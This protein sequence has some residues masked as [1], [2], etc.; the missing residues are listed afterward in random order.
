MSEEKHLCAV[1]VGEDFLRAKISEKGRDAT[2]TY[3]GSG[4]KTFSLSEMADAIE[5]ALKEHF[6]LTSTEPS[7]LESLAIKEGDLVWQQQGEPIADI[8]AS[9]AQITDETAEDIRRVLYE[10]ELPEMGEEGPYD[11]DAHYHKREVDNSESYMSWQEFERRLKTEVR[12]FSLTARETLVSTFEG[13]GTHKTHDRKPIV[14]DAGPAMSLSSLYRARIF[15][16]DEGLEK[17]L[18]SPDKEVGPPPPSLA[19]AGRMNA[20]GIAVFYGATDPLVALAETRPPVGSNVVIGRFE[21]IRPVRLLDLNALRS[22]ETQGSI[23]D[24]NYIKLLRRADFL[25]WLSQRLSTPVMPSDEP[26]GYLATQAIAD[27]LASEASTPLDGIIYPS[28]QGADGVNVVL[29]HKSA[30]VEPID[31]PKGTKMS[32]SL[33]HWTEEGFETDYRVFEHA[34][35]QS[36]EPRSFADSLLSWAF[37]DRAPTLRLDIQTLEVRYVKAVSCDTVQHPVSRRKIESGTSEILRTKMS[38]PSI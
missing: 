29:F 19:T 9:Y 12:F 34:P 13:L 21:L 2:C 22:L 3:C 16:E 7:G 23:F 37:D 4:G 36:S 20:R 33:G 24:R 18:M 30:R 28:I 5:I 1:C 38:D 8:I 31:V 17:A 11:R 6:H 32:A 14:V 15:Q 35:S 27:F 10:R 25:R 26:L